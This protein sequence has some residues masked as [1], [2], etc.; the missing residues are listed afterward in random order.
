[1]KITKNDYE[2]F[3]W[4]TIATLFNRLLNWNPYEFIQVVILMKVIDLRYK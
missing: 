4:L 2:L 3:F 1:M